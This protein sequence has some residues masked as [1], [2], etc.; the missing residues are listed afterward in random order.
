VSATDT[1]FI[2]HF[3]QIVCLLILILLTDIGITIILILCVRN[4]R[5]KDIKWLETL[6]LKQNYQFNFK[7]TN[8]IQ[9]QKYF[10]DV[11]LKQNHC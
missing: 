6:N 4:L 10:P 7:N 3:C 1:Q 8:K 2:L 9:I 11:M 5:H